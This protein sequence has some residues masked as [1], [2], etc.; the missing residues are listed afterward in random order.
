MARLLSDTRG[1]AAIEFALLAPVMVLLALGLADGVR[2]NLLLIDLDAAAGAG[3]AVAR[4][5]GPDAAAITA[6]M[7]AAT[8]R[9]HVARIAFI[10]CEGKPADG[11]CTGL[12]PG[13]YARIRAQ[14][15]MPALLDPRRAPT[16]SATALV[17]LP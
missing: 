12:P 10:G 14:A 5:H 4:D 8:N 1:T 15:D 3:A 2:R 16:L 11:R 9:Q 6:A 17:R 7:A 13:R